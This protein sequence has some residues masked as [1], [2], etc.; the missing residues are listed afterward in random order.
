MYRLYI[1]CSF[2]FRS[3]RTVGISRTVRNII[4]RRKTFINYGFKDVECVIQIGKNY[5]KIDPDNEPFLLFSFM[6]RYFTKILRNFIDYLF[7]YNK[8]NSDVILS[9]ELV[10]EDEISTSKKTSYADF[11]LFVRRS[12]LPLLFNFA[13]FLDEIFLYKSRVDFGKTDILFLPDNF[14]NADFDVDLI[15]QIK[16][17]GAL[18]GLLVHDLLPVSHPE[19]FRKKHSDVFK[20]IVYEMIPIADIYVCNSQFTL[21]ET[22]RVFG[23]KVKKIPSDYFYLGCDFAFNSSA[24]CFP[25][26][27]GSYLMVGTI[28][29]RKNHLYV[30]DAFHSM[31]EAGS[32]ACLVIV[33]KIGWKCESVM[34]RINN[35][36]YLNSNLF[37]Y[38]NA[39]DSDLASLYIG[40]KALIFASEIEG[41][42][43]PLVEAIHYKKI[44]LASYIEIFKEI[45]EDYPYYFDLKKLDSLVHLIEINESI[46]LT[47]RNFYPTLS[48]W[49]GSVN[50]LALKLSNLISFFNCEAFSD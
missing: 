42:G 13:C 22:R 2:T 10:K 16:S 20:K 25:L 36:K 32:C 39:S 35:S 31:W 49:D 12:I 15:H 33:G 27:E 17:N 23:D 11:I 40:C 43:L 5:Y 6:S 50:S 4:I 3:K 21:N 7:F 37:L 41:F 26:H 14:W 19:F 29:P 9:V 48:S 18:L 28:E 46:G 1:D 47:H 44:V 8:K 24:D 38:N 45:A 34:D 30:L